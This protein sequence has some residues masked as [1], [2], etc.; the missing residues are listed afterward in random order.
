MEFIKIHRSIP[1]KSLK[2]L[3]EEKFHIKDSQFYYL[4]RKLLQ[5]QSNVTEFVELMEKRGYETLYRTHE[6]G[7]RPSMLLCVKSDRRGYFSMYGQCI[8]FDVTYN[9]CRRWKS[10]DSGIAQQ[11]GLGIFSGISN[12]NSTIIFGFCLLTTE[13]TEDFIELF[14]GFFDLIGGT[15]QTIVTDEQAAINAALSQLK[16]ERVFT[17]AHVFDNFH[18]LRNLA[19]KVR[20]KEHLEEFKKLIFT[21]SSGTYEDRLL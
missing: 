9:V 15:P 14:K 10:S 1:I 6:D 18:V 4:N 17:G 5:L 13:K 7:R 11:Y 8:I 21:K 20:N 19:R 12:S 2:R 16:R 3:T